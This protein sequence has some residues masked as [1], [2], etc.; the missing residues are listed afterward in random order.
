[1]QA[2]CQVEFLLL[3]LQEISFKTLLVESQLPTFFLCDLQCRCSE[4][5]N[6]VVMEQIFLFLSAK[7]QCSSTDSFNVSCVNF[8]KSSLSKMQCRCNA[9]ST[10]F[11]LC[12]QFNNQKSRTLSTRTT[13]GRHVSSSTWEQQMNASTWPKGPNGLKPSR[14]DP[15]LA[16]AFSVAPAPV[17]PSAQI[18]V[19][20]YFFQGNNP[21]NKY[22]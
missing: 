13:G 18:M 7:S 9:M 12:F 11:F 10:F 4:A 5:L 14:S 6:G 19:I 22:H 3:G 17:T 20:N 16:P 15:A 21:S 1:M 2:L 8:L